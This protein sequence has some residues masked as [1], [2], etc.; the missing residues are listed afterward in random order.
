MAV[1]ETILATIEGSVAVPKAAANLLALEIESALFAEE[2]RLDRMR[3]NAPALFTLL[4]ELHEHAGADLRRNQDD[5]DGPGG[6]WS[7]ATEHALAK[8]ER[9]I[10]KVKGDA[11]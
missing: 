6:Y 4:A 3:D 8:A 5:T 2:K 7:V 11:E 1:R 9:L 10:A